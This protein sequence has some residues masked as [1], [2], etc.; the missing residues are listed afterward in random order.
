MLAADDL[1]DSD[2]RVAIVYAAYKAR[3]GYAA[4]RC[5]S[6]P[7]AWLGAMSREAL[8][9]S[10][11][12]LDELCDTCPSP[13][14]AR[15]LELMV[16]V[17]DAL[18]RLPTSAEHAGDGAEASLVPVTA[19]RQG[20]GVLWQFSRQD[21]S[22][23]IPRARAMSR[24]LVRLAIGRDRACSLAALASLDEQMSVAALTTGVAN[25]I[26]DA[27]SWALQR[28]GSSGAPVQG[29]VSLLA[30][31]C[32]FGPARRAGDYAAVHCVD[33]YVGRRHAG[34]CSTRESFADCFVCWAV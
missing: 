18:E 12:T 19:L 21:R 29:L 22:G 14:V 16:H 28:G 3:L 5:R 1:R 34:L 4:M 26:V 9:A 7:D 10:W 17:W 32:V 33:G 24:L 27:L 23:K 11:A 2:Q 8:L 31:C 13:L 25:E 15:V 30:A 6:E 20:M